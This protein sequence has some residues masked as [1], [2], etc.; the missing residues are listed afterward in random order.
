MADD[1]PRRRKPRASDFKRIFELITEGKSLRAACTELLINRS[2]VSKALEADPALKD[3]YERA[4]EM[5]G[6]HMAENVLSIASAVLSG[7]VLPDRARIAIDA[8]KWA[9]GQMHGTR[10]G[11]SNINATVSG[12]D[13]GPVRV[14]ING[15]DAEL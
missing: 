7:A 9:A 5:R 11:K 6:D 10:W 4:R 8:Y 14:I 3:Q 1:A 15:K 2:L 13:G 12:P